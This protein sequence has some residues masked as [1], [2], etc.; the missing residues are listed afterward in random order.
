MHMRMITVVVQ[1]EVANSA[2]PRDLLAV[3]VHM[4]PMAPPTALAPMAALEVV[5]PA[6]APHPSAPMVPMVAAD[7]V[8]H[9]DLLALV[10]L[11]AQEA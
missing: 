3:R 9:Q 5:A 1:V 11:V 2:P 10:A 7:H 4:G 6:T 8:V